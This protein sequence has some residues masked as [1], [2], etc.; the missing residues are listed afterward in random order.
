MRNATRIQAITVLLLCLLLAALPLAVLA[1]DDNDDTPAAEATAV[2]AED[3]D[4]V[5]TAAEDSDTA[6]EDGPQ[7][8]GILMLLLGVGGVAVVGGS[9]IARDRFTGDD[10]SDD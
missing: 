10:D 7:G 4:T 5:D 1:Q 6:S 2:V 3:G 9:M 8:V